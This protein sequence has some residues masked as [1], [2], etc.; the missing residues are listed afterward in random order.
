MQLC[1]CLNHHLYK[2]FVDSRLIAWRVLSAVLCWDPW[3]DLLGINHM[4]SPLVRI[5]S[6]SSSCCS[7]TF[8]ASLLAGGAAG[9]AIDGVEARGGSGYWAI[10]WARR[11][12]NTTCFILCT[13][14]TGC[15]AE[16]LMW[17]SVKRLVGLR[18]MPYLFMSI[19]NC[20][21]ICWEVDQQCSCSVFETLLKCVM[22]MVLLFVNDV[23][24]V[25]DVD[26]DMK[27]PGVASCPAVCVVV[28]PRWDTLDTAP[29][30]VP[31]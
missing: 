10:T 18:V 4:L 28:S 15:A 25:L 31:L 20:F 29:E 24:Q 22:G 30:T 9:I 21:T 12:F 13:I 5:I 2:I 16:P 3:C 8:D 6:S 11:C 26:W 1:W 19:T 23:E 27:C 7:L 17:F 14:D